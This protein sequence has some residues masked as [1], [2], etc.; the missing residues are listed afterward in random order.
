MLVRKK[1]GPD[2]QRPGF[3]SGRSP[4]DRKQQTIQASDH[5]QFTFIAQQFSDMLKLFRDKPA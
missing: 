3:L 5:P 4:T 2:T 1:R